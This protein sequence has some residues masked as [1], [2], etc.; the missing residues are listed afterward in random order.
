VVT[1]D[2]AD[3]HAVVLS[4]GPAPMVVGAEPNDLGD[5]YEG[6]RIT[7]LWQTQATPPDLSGQDLSGLPFE[8]DPVPG[9]LHWRIVSWPAVE[10]RSVIHRTETVDFL[11]IVSGQMYLGV[12]DDDETLREVLLGPGDTVVALAN[13]HSWRNPGPGP[14]IAVA[15]MLSSL[16]PG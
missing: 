7:E 2:D 5:V 13:M 8:L 15:S 4:D 9:G 10:E 3:G 12:G 16:P 6:F 1:G 11:Y 14:C